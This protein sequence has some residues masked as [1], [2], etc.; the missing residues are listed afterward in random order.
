MS[1][2]KLTFVENIYPF[3]LYP[4]SKTGLSVQ[5]FIECP[6]TFTNQELL[7]SFYRIGSWDLGFWRWLWVPSGC[8]YRDFSNMEFLCSIPLVKFYLYLP[9][10]NCCARCCEGYQRNTLSSQSS[11]MSG[12]KDRQTHNKNVSQGMIKAKMKVCVQGLW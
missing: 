5:Y 4:G 11:R 10:K 12:E 9:C 2:H 7:S 3:A 8:I 1:A 6:A